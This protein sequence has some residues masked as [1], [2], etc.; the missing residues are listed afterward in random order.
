MFRQNLNP[1]FQ[2][3]YH[4]SLYQRVMAQ[5][6]NKQINHGIKCNTD[7]KARKGNTDVQGKLIF[8]NE[9]NS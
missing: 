8:C 9:F 2:Y 5:F 1:A 6:H 7:E 4:N 3:M